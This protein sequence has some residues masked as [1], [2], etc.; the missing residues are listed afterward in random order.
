M[1]LFTVQLHIHVHVHVCRCARF[2]YMDEG[3]A[4]FTGLKVG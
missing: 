2:A 3:G 1:F 4:R